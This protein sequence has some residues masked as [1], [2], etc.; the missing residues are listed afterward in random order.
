[1]V[2]E[3]PQG[4]DPAF[5]YFCTEE[6]AEG[7]WGAKEELTSLV[8]GS[9]VGFICL[10][11]SPFYRSR[12]IKRTL[13]SWG[14]GAD[15]CFRSGKDSGCP[16]QN[17]KCGET[18]NSLFEIRSSHFHDHSRARGKRHTEES[19]LEVHNYPWKEKWERR[20]YLQSYRSHISSTSL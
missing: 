5:L 20:Y 16:G 10:F 12:S 4:A 3:A 13:P 18:R 6:R 9:W 2:P 1:M 14:R 11:F 17:R 7:F 19:S 15:P 8:P